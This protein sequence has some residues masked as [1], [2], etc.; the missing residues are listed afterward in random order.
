MQRTALGETSKQVT[1]LDSDVQNLRKCCCD[2]L[3]DARSRLDSRASVKPI[4]ASSCPADQQRH[5][6]PP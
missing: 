3:M 5:R 1:D 4:D 6:S 2:K